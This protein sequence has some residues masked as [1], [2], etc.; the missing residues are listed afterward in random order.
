[1]AP[2]TQ[3]KLCP[4]PCV[5]RIYRTLVP[6]AVQ[7]GGGGEEDANEGRREEA[8]GPSSMV[9][10]TTLMVVYTTLMTFYPAVISLDISHLHVLFIFNKNW[11]WG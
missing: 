1:M 10:Y 2:R 6:P 7:G 5:D 11:F 3:E 4:L 8:L 9:V